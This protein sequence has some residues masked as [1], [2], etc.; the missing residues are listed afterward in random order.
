M[1]CG[2]ETV[3][4]FDQN[5]LTLRVMALGYGSVDLNVRNLG[6]PEMRFK[7]KIAFSIAVF[8][9]ISVILLISV[10]F[11]VAI[12][13]AAHT[14]KISLFQ[15]PD[16][17]SLDPTSWTISGLLDDGV[18][19]SSDENPFHLNADNSNSKHGPFLRDFPESLDSRSSSVGNIF[20][21]SRSRSSSQLGVQHTESL[22]GGDDWLGAPFA[23]PEDVRENG[24]QSI[25]DEVHYWNMHSG[26]IG[27]RTN[28]K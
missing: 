15:D 1:K 25:G 17:S 22:L 11:V 10:A 12:V 19:G 8:L 3:V 18:D 28:G 26:D 4:E 13:S 14:A 16:D 5:L 27:S 24:E 7:S 20:S 2:W 6:P 9:L 23:V 21:A